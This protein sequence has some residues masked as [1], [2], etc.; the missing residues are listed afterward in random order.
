MNR[1]FGMIALVVVLGVA[2]VALLE[3]LDPDSDKATLN[4]ACE[5]PYYNGPAL[6][7]H[8]NER[9]TQIYVQGKIHLIYPPSVKCEIQYKDVK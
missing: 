3:Y 9:G 2:G 4:V 6:K 7:A 5:E 8:S 1:D